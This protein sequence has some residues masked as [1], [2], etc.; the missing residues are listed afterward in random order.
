MK[1][2]ERLKKIKIRQRFLNL[3]E[4]IKE[5]QTKKIIIFTIV[6]GALLFYPLSGA[7]AL[8]EANKAIDA[9]KNIPILPKMGNKAKIGILTITGLKVCM[10]PNAPPIKKVIAGSKLVCCGG[11]AGANVITTL[12]FTPEVKI[13]T[14]AC[15]AVSWAAL[16]VLEAID[17]KTG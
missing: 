9:S 2:K 3:K 7:R 12:A 11:Y 6:G 1:L 8:E 5:P 10:D 17:A 14:S 16:S 4:R 13:I 15:C